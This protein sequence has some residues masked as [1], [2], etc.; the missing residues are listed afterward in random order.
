MNA[1][2]KDTA[3][4]D[5]SPATAHTQPGP[6]QTATD[7]LIRLFPNEYSPDR[8]PLPSSAT[9]ERVALA[10]WQARKAIELLAGSVHGKLL[11]ADVAEQCA[12]S[13][14]HFTRAFKSTT[15]LSPQ[16]WSLRWR[17]RCALMCLADGSVSLAQ[18]SLDC[19]FADQSHFSRIFRKLV[20]LTPRR[21][22]RERS[23]H[24][25]AA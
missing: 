10:P 24:T 9:P 21:W 15:G 1:A 7:S 13:R 8:S 16:E 3:Q 2:A 14:S 19:G 6:R 5:F 22:Q 20:G 12:L 18:I 25:D 11:I 23:L 17:I 4:A